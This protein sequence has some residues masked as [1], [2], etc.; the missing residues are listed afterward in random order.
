MREHFFE[1]GYLKNPFSSVISAAGKTKVI[2]SLTVENRVPFHVKEGCGWLTAEYSLMPG[3][4]TSRAPRERNHVS[5]RTAEIQRLIGRSLRMAVDLS[6]MPGVS[7]L[8][9]C[10]VLEADGGTRTC[11]VN[12]GMV[13]LAIACRKLHETGVLEKNPLKRWVGAI[14]GGVIDGKTVVDLDYEKDSKAQADFNFVFCENGN[15]IELQ[16]TAEK[17]PVDD[18]KFLELLEKS[19][20]NVL[21]LIEKMKISGGY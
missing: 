18:E 6:E 5:G 8:L 7:M 9:D 16:G 19:R 11:S 14:S 1:T 15:I 10:D 17:E 12:G 3:S 13:A 21:K 4:T 2:V 20:E